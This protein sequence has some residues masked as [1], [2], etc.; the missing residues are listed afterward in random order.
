MDTDRLAN[1]LPDDRQQELRRDAAAIAFFRQALLEAG[2]P[3]GLAAYLTAVRF[4]ETR[5]GQLVTLPPF[6]DVRWV[7]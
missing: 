2:I 3:A 6:T 7:S 4:A 1:L 5:S